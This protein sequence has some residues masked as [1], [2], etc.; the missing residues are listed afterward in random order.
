MLIFSDDEHS[1]KRT[2]FHNAVYFT[3][4]PA[5]AAAAESTRNDEVQIS[6]G[7]MPADSLTILLALCTVYLCF[8]LCLYVL[9]NCCIA[10]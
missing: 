6:N 8:C 3:G 7:K 5:V 2:D 10:N 1:V 4:H 9:L